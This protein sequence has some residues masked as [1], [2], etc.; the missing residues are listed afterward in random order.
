M[1]TPLLEF[2]AASKYFPGVV[3]LEG[4]SMA[5]APGEIRALMAKTAP[6]IYSAENSVR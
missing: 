6:A 5:V 2:E 1:T 3:A 4:V